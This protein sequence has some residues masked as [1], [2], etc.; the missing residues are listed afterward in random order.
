MLDELFKRADLTQMPVNKLFAVLYP[1]FCV[2][3]LAGFHPATEA[4]HLPIVWI[5]PAINY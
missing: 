1:L 3:A 4:V 5:G 2:A